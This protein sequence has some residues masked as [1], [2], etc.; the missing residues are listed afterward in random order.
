MYHKDGGSGIAADRSP[1]RR[2]TRGRRRANRAHTSAPRSAND[3]RFLWVNVSGNV[4][5]TLLASTWPSEPNDEL[6]DAASGRRCT[7]AATRDA[8]ANIRSAQFDR[9]SGKTLVRSHEADG[10]FRPVPSPDGKWLV[11][12]VRH[13]GREALKLRDLATGEDRWLI[14]DVQRDNTQGGGIN[15]RDIYPGSAFTPDSRSLI[16]SFNGKIWR[17]DVPSGEVTAI[18]FT[19]EVDQQM[20]PLAKFDYPINDSMLTVAQIRGARPSPDGQRLAFTALDVLYV[21]ELTPARGGVGAQKIDDRQSAASN[22][23]AEWSS[24]RRSGR[25]TAA[26]SRT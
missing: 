2:R 11:Y 16:T 5:S 12:A 25:P 10:A 14:M 15:D 23:A 17:V 24:M 18:P 19:A 7:A 13:D 1:R 8:S 26:T 6:D 4:P 22:A 3:P 20:G 21:G 9:E